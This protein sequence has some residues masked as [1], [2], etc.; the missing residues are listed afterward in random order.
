M[1]QKA[2]ACRLQCL[3]SQQRNCFKPARLLLSLLLHLLCLAPRQAVWNIST[4][5][6][7][8]CRFADWDTDGVVPN[9]A[10]ATSQVS[11]ALTRTAQ[12]DHNNTGVLIA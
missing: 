6:L 12:V 3:T 7:F 11:D 8:D 9:I 4:L 1:A 5:A 2:P 10:G